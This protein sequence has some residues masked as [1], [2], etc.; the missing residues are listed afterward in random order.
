MAKNIHG[1]KGCAKC[2]ACCVYFPIYE[3]YAPKDAVVLIGQKPLRL[4]K[5]QDEICK[6]L[7][8]DFETKQAS[9]R[10]HECDS[11]ERPP[12]CMN[13]YCGNCD[14]EAREGL[15]EMSKRMVEI[16]RAHKAG[17]EVKIKV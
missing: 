9:C 2:G 5:E 7:D 12:A 13:F 11:P 4:F 10:V 8:Y 3:P 17:L 15:L 1:S 16:M 14:R 6:N